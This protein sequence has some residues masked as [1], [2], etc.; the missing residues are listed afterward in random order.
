MGL[1]GFLKKPVRTQTVSD[2]ELNPL[3]ANSIIGWYKTKNPNATE[4]DVRNFISKMA[5]PAKDLDHLTPEGELPWGWYPA[6]KDFTHSKETEYTYFLNSWLESRG[7]SP[8]EQ[9]GALESFVQY[10]NDLKGLCSK[11]GECF[12]YWRGSLF[13]DAYLEKRTDEL[14]HLRTHFDELSEKYEINQ[15][16]LKDVVPGLRKN[17]KSIIKANPGITQTDVYKM[18][19][20]EA[21]QY[22]SEA[23]YFMEKDGVIVRKKQGRTYT[24]SIK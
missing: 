19:Q 2:E 20:P 14:E 21:K 4:A 8:R 18:F 24:L 3:D 13:D 16:I 15:R 6:H 11:K 1:F 23:L 9:I 22:V 5:E 7:K 12:N 10:M 17:L